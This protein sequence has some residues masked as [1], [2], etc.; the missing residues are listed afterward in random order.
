VDANAPL[1]AVVGLALLAVG[2]AVV[3]VLSLIALRRDVDFDGE[4]KAPGF[5]LNIKITRPRS[6]P[7]D[8]GDSTT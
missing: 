1:F 6:G 7:Q 2:I 5:S 4:I 3:V 8:S